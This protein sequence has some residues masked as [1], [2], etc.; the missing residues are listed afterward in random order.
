MSRNSLVPA[1]C[2]A[3]SLV[4]ACLAGFA[5]LHKGP[6][7]NSSAEVSFYL[8]TLEDRLDHLEEQMEARMR[9]MEKEL[10]VLSTLS[11]SAPA[12]RSDAGLDRT[13]SREADG[14]EDL[15]PG[16]GRIVSRLDDLEMRVRGLEED[17]IERAFSFLDSQSFELRRQGIFALERVAQQDPQARAAIRQMLQDPDP[18]V[19]SAALD[20]L[21]DIGDK[22]SIAGV[23]QLL[24]DADAN[25]RRETIDAL[26][27]LQG[28]EAGADIAQLLRDADP[29]VRERAAD[30]LGQLRFPGGTDLLVQALGDPNERVRGEAIATLGETGAKEAL[31]VLREMY[32]KDSGQHRIRLITAMRALGDEGPYRREVSRLSQTA[33]TA[34]GESDRANAVRTLSWFARDRSQDVFK[35]ALADPSENVRREAQRALGGDREQRR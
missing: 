10:A 11:R 15:A 14:G 6:S 13:E 30:A 4:T 33:L 8:Q 28:R 2:I 16:L 12:P 34:P 3:L 23:S 5:L 24:S 35:Q 26:A 18:R 17:P 21:A 31:P 25:I 20:T 22:E 29:A 7:R 27:R 32:A 19:R 1:F 9:E